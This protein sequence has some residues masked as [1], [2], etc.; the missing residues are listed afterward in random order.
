MLRRSPATVEHQDRHHAVVLTELLPVPLQE[1]VYVSQP[2]GFVDP[3]HKDYV[4][5]LHNALYGHKQAPR[6]WYDHLKKFLL[7]DG[8]VRGVIDP[9]L[10]TK[11]DK[12]D[13]ILC[14]IY[15]DDI[16]FWFS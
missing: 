15:V 14:Q 4:Y 16:I 2:L 6:A 11:R 8:F 7:D 5:K 3:D 9:T 10:F 13:L 1:E 12:G